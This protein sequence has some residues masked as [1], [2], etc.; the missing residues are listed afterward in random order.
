M[1]QPYAHRIFI[2]N[3]QQKKVIEDGQSVMNQANWKLAGDCVFLYVG[4]LHAQYRD[5]PIQKTL[6]KVQLIS[7]IYFEPGYTH[8]IKTY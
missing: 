2:E 7:E 1:H 6:K 8:L 4:T 5:S 3:M